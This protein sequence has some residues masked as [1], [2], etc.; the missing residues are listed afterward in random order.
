MPIAE[1]FEGANTVFGGKSSPYWGEH[2][3]R[4]VFALPIVS[5][6]A[7]LD[8]ACGTGYGLG[9]LMREA[10]TV[11]GLDIDLGAAKQAMSAC[12]GNAGVVLG[13]G[14]TLPFVDGAFD[15]VTSFETIEHLHHRKEFLGELVRVLR[16]D[17]KLIIST[18]NANYTNPVNGK[19]ANP[20][21]IYEYT[22]QELLIELEAHFSV[23]QF[24]GQ[25]LKPSIEIPPFHD[26]QQRL[27]K[28][29]STGAKLIGW[30][31][32][33]KMPMAVREGISE[34][35]WNAPFYPTESDYSFSPASLDTAPVV[36][37]VCEKK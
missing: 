11:T 9:I 33:N 31:I 14:E 30:K 36:V 19:P 17:G 10:K 5:G 26:A 34:I 29:L 13:R 27:P 7:V 3:A 21:H 4:Y 20:F 15:V 32:L 37:A 24:L 1:R 2:A 6:L 22:P 28:D 23:K 25:T 12:G 16:D 18:P 35:I 8:I